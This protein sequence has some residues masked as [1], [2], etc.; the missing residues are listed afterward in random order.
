MPGQV[1]SAT[2]DP[3]GRFSIEGTLASEYTLII[4]G[5]G[6]MGVERSRGV[7][8]GEYVELRVSRVYGATIR[9]VAMDGGTLDVPQE[10]Y[11]RGPSWEILARGAT[12]V[13]PDSLEGA[14]ALDGLLHGDRP[15]R[16]LRLLAFTSQEP[17]ET[18]GPIK[19]QVK[20]PGYLFH[21]G[22]YWATPLPGGASYEIKME[23]E[24][25]GRGSIQMEFLNP[26]PTEAGLDL[27]AIVGTLFLEGD[28]DKI[29]MAVHRR[30]LHQGQHWDGIPGGDYFVR[31]EAK[32]GY[33][34][35]P[36]WRMPPTKI[37]IGPQCAVFQVD[38]SDAGAAL[39]MLDGDYDYS[40]PVLTKV[41]DLA[42]EGIFYS[43]FSAVPGWIDL[44]PAG[45]YEVTIVDLP[46][47]S[48][49]P[50]EPTRSLIEAGSI[51]PWVLPVAPRGTR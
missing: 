37:E 29:N 38:A 44:L 49:G 6:V 1:R 41:D 40:G 51:T 42:N 15:V 19:Y 9:H 20:V 30:A 14:L 12:A 2:T 28:G 32:D 43:A 25:R 23:A 16:D 8:P 21:R 18:L 27:D 7:M 31:F 24:S 11:G 45:R 10:I 50:G 17:A 39:V 26:P 3:E 34:H 13:R 5:K 48:V 35:Y 33:Y 36:S 22:E 46:G 4:Y 47:A